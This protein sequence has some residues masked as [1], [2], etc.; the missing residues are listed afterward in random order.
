MSYRRRAGFTLIELLVVIAIIAILAAILFPVFAQARE[1]ARQATC[2]SNQKQ[3]G[4]AFQMYAT[5]YDGVFPSPGGKSFQAA[6]DI[7]RA[8]GTTWVRTDVVGSQ[9]VDT[10][11][12]YPYIK[13][14]GHGGANN[15]WACPNAVGPQD[16]TSFFLGQNY[17]MNDYVRG[18]NPGQ[19]VVA[20]SSFITA[21]QSAS[22]A[23][24]AIVDTFGVSP[25]QVILV[26]EAAQDNR[27]GL[28]YG[29]TARNG[30]PYFSTLNTSVTPPLPKN[31]PQT[32]HGGG[33]NFLFCDGHVK[34]MRPQSTWTAATQ[35][36]VQS[37]NPDLARVMQGS[38]QTDHWNPVS[39]GVV[40]P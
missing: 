31:A 18:S 29:S 19:R 37:F 25:A 5:D 27:S 4:T 17:V 36:L 11:G 39:G 24:G 23:S 34:W 13:Q 7:S 40:Y 21:A 38:G 16:K 1:K 6:G 12:I 10:G 30:S 2:Q 9:A 8:I 15:V 28:N 14:R 33:S 20:A 22:Y 3:I 32:Y 26:F 35:P